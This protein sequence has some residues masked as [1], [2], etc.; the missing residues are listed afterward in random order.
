MRRDTFLIYVHRL[1]DVKNALIVSDIHANAPAL[2]AVL[3]AEPDCDSVVFLGDAVDCGPHPEVVCER[4]RSRDL[5]AGVR[6]NH[7]RAVLDAADGED[8]SDDPYAEWKKWTHGRLS[9]ESHDFLRSLARTTTVTASDRSLRLHH[10]D[11]PQPEGH[12][13]EWSTRVTPEDDTALF[14]TV[15]ARYDEDVIVHGHSHYPYEATVAGTTF[16]NPGSVGLQRPG[17]PV[18][19]AHYAVFES[20]TFDLRTV[21]YDVTEVTTD[22]EAL[23]SPFY[24]VWDRPAA[25]A[26]TA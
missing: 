14:K 2:E 7:D 19:R 16:I 26:S 20:G 21:S 15:T 22:L 17:R 12:D 13:G 6:G 4:L 3:A 11:F 18:N 1:P 8:L 5:V 25:D 10:G 23:E 24:E 9:A